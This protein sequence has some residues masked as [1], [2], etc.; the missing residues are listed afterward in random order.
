MSSIRCRG[1]LKDEGLRIATKDRKIPPEFCDDIELHLSRSIPTLDY[2][3][4]LKHRETL[5]REV[6]DELFGRTFYDRTGK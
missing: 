1:F 6:T 2:Y 3:D 5:S 4:N